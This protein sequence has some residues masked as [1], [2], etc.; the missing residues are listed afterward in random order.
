MEQ[1]TFVIP[2]YQQSPYLETC[3]SS[4]KAQTVK[5]KII[6]TT[7]TPGSSLESIAHQYDL[8]YFVN[9]TG[10]LGIAADWNFALSKAATPWVTIAHQDDIYEP[11]YVE[12]LL[13]AVA[14]QSP[15]TL[16]A[17]SNYYDIVNNAPK[18][19]SLNAFVKRTLL[20]PFLIKPAIEKRFLKKSVLLFG[21]PICCPTVMIN[22]QLLPDFNFSPD[23]TCALDWLAW[24]QLAQKKGKF[25]YTA[26]KLVGHRIHAGSETTVQLSMGKRQQEEKMIFR[27]MWGKYAGNLLSKIYSAG[28]KQNT[29]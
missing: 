17:F 20:L 18:N 5:S 8:P 19:N 3:I 22:K 26:K 10:A 11:D 13:T 6:I 27:M 4:L 15:H 12:T 28:H 9:T 1:H 25:V 7:S 23:F 16:I 21:D 14:D 2:A 29:L 24:Y